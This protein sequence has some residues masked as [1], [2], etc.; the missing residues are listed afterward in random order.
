MPAARLGRALEAGRVERITY[1]LEVENARGDVD[2]RSAELARG[3]GDH[4]IGRS[5]ELAGAPCRGDGDRALGWKGGEITGAA[6]HVGAPPTRIL[7][8]GASARAHHAYEL[9]R[10]VEGRGRARVA[11]KG[12]LAVGKRRG[13][14]RLRVEIVVR[15][16]RVRQPQHLM[17]AGRAA[18]FNVI[19]PK[20][21]L[22]ATA[23]GRE[24]ESTPEGASEEERIAQLR[25]LVVHQPQVVERQSTP[26]NTRH[27]EPFGLEHRR[28]AHKPRSRHGGAESGRLRA[29]T[30]VTRGG[31]VH[32]GWSGRVPRGRIIP[33]A[34]FSQAHEFVTLPLLAD[35]YSVH[36]KWTYR[37][38]CRKIQHAKTLPVCELRRGQDTCDARAV[39]ETA[40]PLAARVFHRVQ[41]VLPAPR[42]RCTSVE[43]D[44][45]LPPKV[46]RGLVNIEGAP[47]PKAR[48]RAHMLDGLLDREQRAGARHARLRPRHKVHDANV[49]RPPALGKRF[50]IE[51]SRLDSAFGDHGGHGSHGGRSGRISGHGGHLT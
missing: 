35:P 47:V 23:G 32:A 3:D 24:D 27:S 6:A 16:A 18:P 5:A 51:V 45:V 37:M 29:L 20:A 33:Q 41:F 31:V 17:V 9:A 14:K 39:D 43:P 30:C 49:H 25:E 8:G 28:V 4:T 34:R 15:G 1:I 2:E 36:H 42:A 10:G 40:E 50:D 13:R 11:Q 21:H 26:R 12:G 46:H 44:T 19:G 38:Q 48:L 22:A 7:A